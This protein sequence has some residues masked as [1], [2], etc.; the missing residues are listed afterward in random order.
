MAV[1][2]KM[3]EEFLNGSKLQIRK[4]L[5]DLIVDNLSD[6]PLPAK[7]AVLAAVGAAF[8]RYV[9]PINI[10]WVP[11]LLEATV[12]DPFLKKLTVRFASKAYDYIASLQKGN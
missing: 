1:D 2:F 11:A 7:D 10:P 12:V 9:A 4:R 8:D 3:P 5:H 6:I